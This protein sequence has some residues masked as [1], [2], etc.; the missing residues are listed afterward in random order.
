MK[1][2]DMMVAMRDGSGSW[3]AKDFFSAD[4]VTPS[5]DKQQDVKLISA[6]VKQNSTVLVM[7]RP[8][9]SCDTEDW[10]IDP[11]VPQYAIWAMGESSWGYHG[12]N[13]Q[14]QHHHHARSEARGQ[15]SSLSRS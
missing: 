3:T 7:E 2:A 10:S 1:G 11:S 4:Y 14:G 13:E 15:S 6:E 8:L 12:N 9:E 5:L